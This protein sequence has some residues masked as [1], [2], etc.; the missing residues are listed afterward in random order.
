MYNAKE[1][2]FWQK[3]F[4]TTRVM[5]PLL[6]I[7]GISAIDVPFYSSFYEVRQFIEPAQAKRVL[8]GQDVESEILVVTCSCGFIEFIQKKIERKILF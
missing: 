8:R 5:C 2:L 4:H 6:C 1:T 3:K 7:H